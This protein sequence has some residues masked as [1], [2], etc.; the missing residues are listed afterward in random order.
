[1]AV[2]QVNAADEM[3]SFFQELET[4]GMDA[5]WRQRIRN[6]GPGYQAF[7]WRWTDV[8]PFTDRATQLVKPGPEAERRVILLRNPTLPPGSGG[9]THTLTAAVQTVLPG[10]IAP[11]H[12]HTAA[13]IRFILQGKGTVTMV[14]GE[15]CEMNVGDL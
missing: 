7:R 15:P 11:S 8:E 3:E 14:N 13:A 2:D 5:L 6:S 10:E 4:K 9:A 12:R 1:M